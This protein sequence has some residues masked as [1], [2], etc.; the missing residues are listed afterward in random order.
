MLAAGGGEWRPVL[1][2]AVS[3]FRGA[4]CKEEDIRNALKNHSQVRGGGLW[5][6]IWGRGRRGWAGGLMLCRS[7]DPVP[8]VWK[9]PAWTLLVHVYGWVACVCACACGCTWGRRVE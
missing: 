3:L 7:Q 4:N 1:D 5:E 9:E 6:R 2:E 8:R